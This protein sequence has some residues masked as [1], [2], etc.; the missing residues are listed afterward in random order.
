MVANR[1]RDTGPEMALRRLLHARGLRYRVDHRPLASARY[2]AD[3]VFT[4]VKL[5]VFVDGCF[6]HGCP[7]HYQPSKSHAEYWGPKIAANR[8]RDQIVDQLLIDA[9]WT[10]IRAWEHEDPE[11]VAALVESAVRSSR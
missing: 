3:I 9:G 11:L 4:R 1:R 8:E 5:A 10:V 2:R 7:E 6:W